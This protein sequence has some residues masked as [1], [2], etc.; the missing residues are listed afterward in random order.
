MTDAEHNKKVLDVLRRHYSI[1]CHLTSSCL[2][3]LA[4]E[5]YHKSLINLKAKKSPC[6]GDIYNLLRSL[7]TYDLPE[8]LEK[9]QAFLSCLA[10]AEGPAK[11]EA[12]IMARDL[13]QYAFHG[14]SV[15]LLPEIYH[16]NVSDCESHSK[17]N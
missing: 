16:M 5:M 7:C 14:Q 2:Q 8:L 15:V 6:F 1:L 13:K 11:L 4:D 3:E 17:G 9:L 12:N 10:S